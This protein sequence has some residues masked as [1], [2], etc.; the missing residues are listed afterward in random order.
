MSA[1]LRLIVLVPI[2][3]IAALA[4]AAIV[5]TVGLFGGEVDAE[6]APIILGV[7]I[8]VTLYGGLSS[9][10]PALLAIVA[11]EIM[12][13]RSIFYWLAVGGLIG[14]LASGV[15]EAYGSFDVTANLLPI[16]LAGGFAGGFVYWLIAGR[17]SGATP[18]TAGPAR[19]GPG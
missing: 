14:L 15:T 7:A 13:W 3:Y 10:F 6:T 16:Y 19:P 18:A 8:G 17:D 4:A 9:F 5:V 1:L 2:A 12:A 11:G